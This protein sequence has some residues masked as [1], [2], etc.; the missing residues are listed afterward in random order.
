MLPFKHADQEVVDFYARSQATPIPGVPDFDYK[1]V[2]DGERKI[3]F[4]KPLPASSAG[5]TFEL[6]SKVLGVYDKGKPGSVV[7]T[8]QVIVDKGSGEVYTRAV[9]SAFFVGQ[10]GWGGPKGMGFFLLSLPRHQLELLGLL[11]FSPSLRQRILILML[12]NLSTQDPRMSATTL[13]KAALPA[14]PIPSK[15]RTKLHSSTD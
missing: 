4:I 5:R 8:E 15:R 3:S 13:Q 11:S 6:R 1:R 12:T 14:Q 7:E 10:G 2:V 9:G